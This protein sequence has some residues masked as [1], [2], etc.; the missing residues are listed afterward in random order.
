MSWLDLFGFLRSKR[1]IFSAWQI[2]LT[3][4]CPL[5]CRMCI[6]EG[7]KNWYSGDMNINNFKEIVQ[8][9][10][11][12]ETIV[13]EGWGESLLHKN[14]IE[15]IRLAKVEG[16]EVGF[17]TS[18]MGL[19]EDYISELIHAGV[20]FIGFSF[21]GATA[22]THNS[23]RINSYFQD[24]VRNI[25]TLNE[26]KA[27]KKFKNPKL[28]IV[29]LMLKDNIL[30]VPALIELAKDIGIEEV[31][32]TN[33]IHITN[34]WQEKQRVFRCN[35]IQGAKGPRGQVNY[36]NPRILESLNPFEEILKE[37]ELKAKEL[38]INLRR[39]SLSPVDVP[40]CE[41]NPLRNLYISIDGEV[42]PC[43]YLYPP[44][45]S[46]FRRIFC[47]NVHEIQRVSFG[48]IFKEPLH[49]I[50]GK[51]EYVEFRQGF[52]LR[53]M[54]FEEMYSPFLGTERPERFETLPLSEPPEQCKTCH[55]VLGV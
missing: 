4:R 9:F 19:N 39:P 3:T 46:P 30:E 48:N 41:E 26:I 47:S 29:Y 14:L 7:I 49:T 24:L 36:L 12:V 50:W 45:S 27:D 51:K 53:K 31:V 22:K 35:R 11:D 16:P 52:I 15:C 2:E 55:K 13:L 32:L 17:V 28:H 38:K 37:A 10:K 23:I 5:R 8:Y 1:K 25:Q 6:R 34:E 42:S 44:V 21:A 20:D 54:R 18:G 40:V 33:L 43:V